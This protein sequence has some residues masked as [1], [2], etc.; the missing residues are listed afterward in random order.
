MG[1]GKEDL[2]EVHCDLDVA[3]RPREVPSREPS[4]AGQ[5]R[6]LEACVRGAGSISAQLS[7]LGWPASRA[8]LF[9][10]QVSRRSWALAGGILTG[11]SE[12]SWAHA[13]QPEPSG[14]SAPGEEGC[15]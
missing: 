4:R 14:G 2:E 3:L 6:R 9:L 15:E 12:D 13:R 7:R 5:L 11:R 10:E 1:T 8:E